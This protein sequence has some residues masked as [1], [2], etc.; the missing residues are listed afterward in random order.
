MK[1]GGGGNEKLKNGVAAAM[2]AYRSIGDNEN[3]SSEKS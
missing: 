3:V 2:A 1:I